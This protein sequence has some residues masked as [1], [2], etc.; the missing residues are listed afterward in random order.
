M[1]SPILPTKLPLPLLFLVANCN[2]HYFL[3]NFVVSA[4]TTIGGAIVDAGTFDWSSGKFPFFTEPSPG[5]HGLKFWDAFKN[6]SFIIRARVE[7]LRDLGP[8][9]NPFGSFLLIQGLE[10]LSLRV[11]RHVT[12]SLTLAKWLEERKEVDWVLYPGLK[13][14]P[15]HDLAQKY[16][17]RGFG[18]ILSFGIKGGLAAGKKFIDAVKL[19]S[20]LANVGDAKS[21]VIHPATT[22]HQQLSD[23]EQLASGVKPELVR[24]SVGIEHIDD[25]IADVEQALAASQKA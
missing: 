24:I 4:R 19:L 1:I 18:G 9:Q 15:T 23:E 3:C 25:I 6:I 2:I 5:Y 7:V 21:L 13:S 11:E 20:H 14:H 16:L 22:T 17:K 8:C 10:T 12:N